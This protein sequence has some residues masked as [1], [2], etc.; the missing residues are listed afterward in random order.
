MKLSRD[1]LNVRSDDRGAECHRE[2]HG[3]D[4]ERAP[5]FL[6]FR[7]VLRVLR[8]ID[9]ERHKVVFLGVAVPRRYVWLDD[10]TCDGFAAVLIEVG[11]VGE[12]TGRESEILF[13]RIS[14]DCET[15]VFI[16][17]IQLRVSTILGIQDNART[18]ALVSHRRGYCQKQSV[19]GLIRIRSS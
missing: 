4:H 8:V 14:K 6:E 16:T 17:M 19:I 7:P 18:A 3:R 15:L 1:V 10:G 2:A 12:L 9:R 11:F 5:P 13:S